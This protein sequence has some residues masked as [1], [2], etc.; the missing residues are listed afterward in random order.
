MYWI[1]LGRFGTRSICHLN[2]GVLCLVAV[3]HQLGGFSQSLAANPLALIGLAL[4]A[5]GLMCQT[6]SIIKVLMSLRRDES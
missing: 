5:G 4:S 2:A 1:S 6:A 3:I